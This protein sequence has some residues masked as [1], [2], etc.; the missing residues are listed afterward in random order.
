[1][2]DTKH[3]ESID[4]FFDDNVD[5]E[6]LDEY[7]IAE[8]ARLE[9]KQVYED[10]KRLREDA[11][12]LSLEIREQ[13]NLVND[14]YKSVSEEDVC[15]RLRLAAVDN[16]LSDLYVSTIKRYRYYLKWEE[17]LKFVLSTS[18]FEDDKIYYH[19][20]DRISFKLELERS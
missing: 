1:M 20:N 8:S 12:H 19:I 2:A 17:L 6:S 9:T 7:N 15:Y 14:A 10:I 11:E 5:F 3:K 4:G 13:I 16:H 18:I